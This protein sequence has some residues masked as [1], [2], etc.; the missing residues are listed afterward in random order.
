V[1]LRRTA[2]ALLAFVLTVPLLGAEDSGCGTTEEAK[3]EGGGK[4][5]RVGQRLT[6]KGTTYRVTNVRTAQVIGDNEFTREEANGSFVVVKLTLTNRK[7][8]P[9]T[10]LEDNIRLIGGNGKNY[11]TSDDAI[12]ALGGQTF[13]L[14]EIQ[15]DVT[16]RGTLV[17]D[18]P[19]KALNGARLQV[20]DLFSNSKGQIRLGL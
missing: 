15:P 3:V 20:E 1:K 10:I 13:L 2:L 4:T 11:S 16:E 18:V 19:K 6:L 8:E 12:L 5:A 14:E 9:A 17:Y 7:D